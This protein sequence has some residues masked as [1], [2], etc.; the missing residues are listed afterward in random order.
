MSKSKTFNFFRFLVVT[1][2]MFG[3]IVHGAESDKKYTIGAEDI[4]NIRVLDRSELQRTIEVSQNGYI[5]FPMIGE[6]KAGGLTIFELEKAISEKLEADGFL[7]DAQVSIEVTQYGSMSVFLLGEVRQAGRYFIKG[8]TH[9]LSIIAEAGGITDN[10][11]SDIVIIRKVEDVPSGGT[12]ESEV[13]VFDIDAVNTNSGSASSFVYPGDTIQ[14]PVA[15]RYYVSGEVNRA[16]EFKWEKELSVRRAIA[17]AGG[18]T[19]LANID[20]V[21]IQRMKDGKE[22]SVR[23]KMTDFVQPKDIIVVHERFF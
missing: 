23:P 1:I 2:F 11:G 13:V 3:S 12:T 18:V 8:K 17:T 4:L 21:T 14:V 20:K 15:A 5:S 9:V 16:G 7:V 10:A 6:V 19:R 22:I